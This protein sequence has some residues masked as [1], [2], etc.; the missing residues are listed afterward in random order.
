MF[1]S[2]FFMSK[3]IMFSEFVGPEVLRLV[4]ID[5]PKA[6]PGQVRIK[7]RATSV[8]PMDW[9]VTRGWMESLFPTKLPSIPGADVAGVVDQ[10]GD[11]VTGVSV[12][13]EVFGW[14]VGGAYAEYALL[15]L[16]AKKPENMPWDVAASLPTAG[17]TAYRVLNELNVKSGETLLIHAAAGGVGSIAVQIAR[18]LGATVIG[19]ASEKNHGYLRSLGATPVTYGEGLVDRVRKIAPQGVDSVFDASGQ[20]ALPASIEL[21]GGTERVI[22]IADMDAEKHGV[23][24][25]LNTDPSAKPLSELARLYTEGKLQITVEQ[26]FPLAEAAKAYEVSEAGHLRGKIVL[27]IG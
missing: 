9:K 26:I 22:T 16:F 5:E 11:G 10:V 14:A 17:E 8:N 2:G 20:G 23:K 27:Q 18:N 19:T 6:G 13:D 12:G 4:D 15:Q 3:A 25:S 7:V 21:T 24:F 1:K